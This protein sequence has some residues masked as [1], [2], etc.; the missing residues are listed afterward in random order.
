MTVISMGNFDLEA[1]IYSK[2]L[3]TDKVYNNG[4]LPI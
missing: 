4:S 3:Y 1:E 2:G